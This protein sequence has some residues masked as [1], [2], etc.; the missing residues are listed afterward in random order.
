MN[1]Y[2]W[3]DKPNVGDAA[4]EYIVRKLSYEPI[5]WKK[6]QITLYTE[7]KKTIAYLLKGKLYIPQF[8]GYVYP[9]Q[10]CLFAVGS[11]M[12]YSNYKTICWG[13]GFREPHSKLRGG[14]VIA[15]RGKFSRDLL[16]NKKD[17]PLGDPALLLPLIY[18]PKAK[19]SKRLIKIVPHFEDYNDIYNLYK[20]KY[21]IIDIRTTNV[22]SFIDEVI[23]SKYILSTSLHGL[24]I[25]HAYGIPALWIKKGPIGSS[26]FKFL[27]YFSSV[28]IPLY[29]GFTNIEEILLNDESIE[30]LF[31]QNINKSQINASLYNIQQNLLRTAP[32]KLKSEYA[33]KVNPEKMHSTQRIKKEKNGL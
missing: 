15:V 10:K 16:P 5:T 18:T 29:E 31:Q 4:S 19:D 3:N 6:P 13:T 7:L 33:S 24:I 25:A 21:N 17:I 2:W 9:W 1:I 20:N 30:H 32:F 22:E 28:N 23:S 26:E 12:D 8:N 11:I 14:K 27:D